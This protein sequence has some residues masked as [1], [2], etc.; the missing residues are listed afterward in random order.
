MD[1]PDGDY[2]QRLRRRIERWLATRA[3]A[4]HRWAEMVFLAPDLLHLLCRLAVDRDVPVALRAQVAAAVAYFVFAVDVI[5]EAFLGPAGYVDDVA[6]AA[7]VLHAVV[8]GTSA[9][10]VQRHWAGEGD[11]LVVIRRILRVTEQFIG[12]GLWG[13]V[14][15]MVARRS[16]A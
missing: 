14:K 11:V 2:Y 10:I 7:Y 3:G 9:A 13:R 5:P 8:N 4:R 6:L 12:R 16:F 15:A 1:L